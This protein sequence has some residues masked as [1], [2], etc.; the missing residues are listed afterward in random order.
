MLRVPNQN[1]ALYSVMALQ[2]GTRELTVKAARAGATNP[3]QHQCVTVLR[4]L[5]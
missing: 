1:G 5:L 2:N 4:T 3:W